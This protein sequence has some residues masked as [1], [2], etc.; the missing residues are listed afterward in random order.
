[1]ELSRIVQQY[2]APSCLGSNQKAGQEQRTGILRCVQCCTLGLGVCV[3]GVGVHPEF[4][5]DF[6][7]W[8]AHHS[9]A[10]LS[11]SL[12]TTTEYEPVSVFRRTLRSENNVT[13]HETFPNIAK[14]LFY[15]NLLLMICVKKR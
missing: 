4:T 9:P 14:I 15:L 5:V 1:M 13:I 2:T 12:Y 7:T 3:H 10:L 11:H 8:M 6:L